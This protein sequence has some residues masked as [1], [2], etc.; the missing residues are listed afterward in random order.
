MII[1]IIIIPPAPAPTAMPT[2]VPVDEDEPDE[3]LEATAAVELGPAVSTGV[4]DA[5]EPG[6]EELVEVGGG[7]PVVFVALRIL[8]LS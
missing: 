4:S 1:A 8:D 3:D 6:L 2:V 7:G 5:P